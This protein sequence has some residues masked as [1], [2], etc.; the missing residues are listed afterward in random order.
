[1]L[2]LILYIVVSLILIGLVLFVHSI[3]HAQEV[4]PKEPFIWGDYNPKTTNIV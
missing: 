4:D 1:M 3:K 2:T